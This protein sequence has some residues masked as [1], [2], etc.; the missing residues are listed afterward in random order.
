[1]LLKELHDA[2]VEADD[3]GA[4]INEKGVVEVERTPPDEAWDGG[5]DI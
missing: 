4:A 5:L 3:K 2:R 1:M